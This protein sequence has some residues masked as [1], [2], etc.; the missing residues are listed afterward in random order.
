MSKKTLRWI[1]N[2]FFLGLIFAL[3]L[4]GNIK[5]W[6]T[7]ILLSL[8]AI[9]FWGRLYCGWIC[10]IFTSLR[11]WEK[12]TG[13]PTTGRNPEAMGK[14][15][16]QIPAI[17]GLVVLFVV[18]NKMESP[19]PYFITLIP[20][21]LLFAYFFGQARWHRVCPL[22]VLFSLLNSPFTKTA[23][24]LG[25]ICLGCGTC[26]DVCPGGAISLTGENI[27]IDNKY[28]LSCGSCLEV[29]PAK[30]SKA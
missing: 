26:I 6:M 25:D 3:W 9:P 28:C 11:L 15:W 13:K 14:M 21:A 16:L 22:G 20:I 17:A 18:L 5:L 19:V 7:L 23:P 29:C 4:S 30:K 24:K 2:L 27:K 10:P 1:V 8:I 12:V